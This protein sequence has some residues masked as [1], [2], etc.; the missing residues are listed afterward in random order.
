MTSTDWPDARDSKLPPSPLLLLT[1]FVLVGGIL[2]G[3]MEENPFWWNANHVFIPYCTSDSWSGI[4][5][6]TRGE[7]FSFMGSAI[8]R[9]VVVD[10]VSLGLKN[11]NRPAS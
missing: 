4:K 6:H 7:M 1:F 8:V 2:S 3:T 10:L 11:G 9:Q 5:P